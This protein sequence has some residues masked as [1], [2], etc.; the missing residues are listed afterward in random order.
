MKTLPLLLALCLPL[1]A[2]A[3]PALKDIP[4]VG[5]RHAPAELRKDEYV[6]WAE[7]LLKVTGTNLASP[8][9]NSIFAWFEANKGAE[10]PAQ[11][12]QDADKIYVDVETA[13]K[14]ILD[15]EAKGKV[16]KLTGAGANV[17]AELAA[18]PDQVL[19]ANL[20]LWGKPI[21]Q[22]N[23]RTRPRA[24]PS[25]SNRVNYFA[26]NPQW[27]PNAFASLEVRTGGGIVKDLND[28][29]V[30]L[31]R[32]DSQ[33]GYEVLMQF[34]G[35]RETEDTELSQTQNVLAIAV[36]RPIG[37]GKTAFKISSR[38]VGQTTVSESIRNKYTFNPEKIRQIQMS[39]V[40]YVKELVSTG[41]IVDQKV[42]AQ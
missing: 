15:L 9:T 19:N 14:E 38:Y 5:P 24:A 18:T 25:H 3:N 6:R 16:T 32:G 26:P 7:P 31:V 30:V 8:F 12:Q 34:L 13:K 23:G 39:F 2:L 20:Y 42:A 40:N 37:N 1:T 33:K 36:I 28:R 4:D 11:V 10:L 27:G 29:Y 21:G 17:Y 41:K 22:S 35:V